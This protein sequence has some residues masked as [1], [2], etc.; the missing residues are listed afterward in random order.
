LG[1][2]VG[3]GVIFTGKKKSET[4]KDKD[5]KSYGLHKSGVLN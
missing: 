3:F 5:G 2:F 4:C 1:F